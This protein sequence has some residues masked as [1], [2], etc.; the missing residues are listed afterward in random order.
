MTMDELEITDPAAH[1]FS[2]ACADDPL[3]AYRALRDRCPVSRGAGMLEGTHA[4]YLSRYEDV[5]WALKHPETFSSSFEAVSIGQEHPLIPLQ[6]DPPEHAKYRR[7]LDPEFAPKKMAALEPD[8]RVLVNGI[9]DQF[10]GN[11][12]CDFHEEFATPL[13][14][15]MFLRLMGMPQSDLP[16]LLQ[17]RDDTIR[18]KVEPD[19]WE[20][21]QRIREETGAKITRYFEEAIEERRRHPDDSAVLGRIV[22]GQ[23]E[24]RPLTDEELLGICHLLLLGGLDTVTATLDCMIVY[25]AHHPE[26]RAALVNNPVVLA[27]AVEELLRTET[28]VM[29]VPRV[30]KQDTTINGVEVKAGDHATLCL[31]AANGDDAEF[32][33]ADGV[34]FGRSP[35]RHLAFGGGAHRCLGSHLARLELRVAL[36]EF[37]KRI[38]EYEIAPA[39]DIHYSPG[40]RQANHLPL[41]FGGGAAQ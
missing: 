12:G 1:M 18:P 38:P 26:R 34:D 2:Q 16:L 9:I 13:P 35:N 27:G 17:W 41:V 4:V 5:Q 19:D 39:A 15:T 40:I 24:G 36:E 20:G 7:L 10:V 11:G 25:L 21:A 23:V 8:A 22:A 14:S 29:I 33:D 30:V 6:I 3:P 28:P 31:G 37:H 32:D